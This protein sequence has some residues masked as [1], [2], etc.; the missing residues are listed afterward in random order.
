MDC[1]ATHLPYR[2]TNH[3][4]KIV[5]D[6]IDQADSL[7][8]FY[9][10]LP[11]IQGVQ[12]AIEQRKQF[13]TDR[14]SLVA[15]LKKQYQNITTDHSVL[16]NIDALLS[17]DTFTI[18]TAHQTNL[19]SGPLYFI[20]KIAH[21]IKLSQTL[22][23][24]FPEQH[25]V[26]VF[27]IGSEDAD[28]DELNHVWLGGEKYTW[29]TNQKGAVG[30]MKS[31]IA[32][33]KLIDDIS[34]QLNVLPY[35]KEIHTKV[36]EFYKEGNTIQEATFY[37]INYLFSEFGLV[38]LLPDNVALKRSMISIFEDDLFNQTA[39][40]IVEKS[41]TQ[42]TKAGYKA[43]AYPR[44]INL[45]Y[46]KDD[47]RE[48]IERTGDTFQVVN[49]DIRFSKTDLLE[50]L[51]KHPYH[52]SPN[53]ILRG[54]YQEIILPNIIFVGGGGE[55]AYWLQLKTLFE[56]YKV[57]F[58]ILTLRNSFL[59]IVTKW[60][61][62]MAQINLS[63]TDFFEPE[64]NLVNRKIRLET[65]KDLSVQNAISAF[66]KTYN[67]LRNQVADIDKSLENHVEALKT[68]T[69]ARIT[70]L[71]KK[72]LRAEKRKFTDLQNQIHAIYKQ[73]FPNNGLQERKD[74]VLYYYSK[75]GRGFINAIVKNSNSLEQEFTILSEHDK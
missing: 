30:R 36:K 73:L 1:K 38:V 15:E 19:F 40:N 71:E 70:E 48:R 53:V 60:R 3:F 14:K 72:M 69:I 74:N 37:F 23:V 56:Q 20:Y 49:T 46:L 62:K 43:Q 59:I 17:E 35:G 39:S 26:P 47:I 55:T 7:Q 45:F 44:A 5:L 75:W 25:F 10:L 2:E 66:A 29:N 33:T 32:L 63:P 51:K 65:N 21:V 61:E 11:S 42:L 54:L 4:S 13:D 22:K 68:R 9:N 18:T 12:K 31:D 64:M 41:A 27:Y 50:E 58:P 8:P 28:L 24:Q 67:E 16:N 34:G 52:F 57:P 6:Y